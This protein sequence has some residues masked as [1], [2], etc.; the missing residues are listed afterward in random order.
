MAQAAEFQHLDTTLASF[1]PAVHSEHGKDRRQFF[2]REGIF[3]AN[4]RQLRNQ[5]GSVRGNIETGFLRNERGR[6][7]HDVRID[8]PR[9]VKH[10]P[11]QFL[12]FFRADEVGLE[13]LE[14]IHHPRLDGGVDDHSR[15]R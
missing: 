10:C 8:R 7:P 5:T 1:A 11:A 15:F 3:L 6:L 9:L 13:L 14:L 12:L 2:S 4:R